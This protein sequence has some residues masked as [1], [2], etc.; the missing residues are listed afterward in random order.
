MRVLVIN[1]ALA[2]LT[3]L[4]SPSAA[5]A[6][7]RAR[8]SEAGRERVTGVVDSIAHDAIGRL[9]LPPDSLVALVATTPLLRA[10]RADA[11]TWWCRWCEGSGTEG[12]AGFRRGSS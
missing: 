10:R 1:F 4:T 7:S 9:D 5:F 11:R 8:Q 6:Q 3:L 12:E 2:T